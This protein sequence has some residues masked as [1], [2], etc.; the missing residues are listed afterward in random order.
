[1]AGRWLRNEKQICNQKTRSFLTFN[2]EYLKSMI[3]AYQLK[4]FLLNNTLVIEIFEPNSSN[5]IQN[6]VNF[7]ITTEWQMFLKID[8]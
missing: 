2:A 8:I 6:L 4:Q 7:L 3:F 1:M 5:L